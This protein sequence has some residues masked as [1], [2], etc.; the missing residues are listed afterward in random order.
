MKISITY[1]NLNWESYDF[2]KILDSEY[3]DVLF[4]VET[5]TGFHVIL[6]EDVKEVKI[7]L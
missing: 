1:Q 6:K 2:V 3:S 4:I 7:T 5:E